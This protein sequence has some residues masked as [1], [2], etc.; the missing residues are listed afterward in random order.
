MNITEYR[1]LCAQYP[2]LRS[3]FSVMEALHDNIAIVG[4]DGIILWVSS[5][6]ERNYGISRDEVVGRT[7]YELE[8]ERVFTPSVAALVLKTRRVVTLTETSQSGQLNIVTGVPVYDQ[9]GDISLVVSYTVDPAY[10]LRLYDEYQNIL[11]AG[12]PH[13]EKNP[14]LPYGGVV[15]ASAAMQEVLEQ[16]RKVADLETGILITGEF[17][18]GKNVVARLLHHAGQRSSGPLVEI[19][20]AGIPDSLLESELFG[21]ESGSFTGARQRGKP[22]RIEQAHGGTL[23]LDEVGEIPLPLQAKL[24]EVIQEKRF[25]KLGA[26][27]PTHVDFRLVAA[28]NQDLRAL[29]RKK[30]F[31]SDLFFRLSTFPLTI[32]PL[33][34]R[35]ED[36][37]PPAGLLPAQDQRQVRHGQALQHSRP[38]TPACLHL[39]GER[40]RIAKH[41]GTV[42]H[43]R[44]P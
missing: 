12:A 24:L 22:G 10:S 30:R 28:T 13:E 40:A 1:T 27:K 33:R 6:F 5:C 4:K 38:A 3:L 21:Y 35:R 26:H 25:F 20:C 42:R 37:S 19:N 2:S 43:H 41:R 32:P 7:T 8:A 18:V 29:V 31:R 39:A 44:R 16:V 34:D 17:G 15:Y 23:F 14:P 9:N 36:I 11:S